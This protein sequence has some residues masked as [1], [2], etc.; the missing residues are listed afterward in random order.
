[1]IAEQSRMFVLQQKFCRA[2]IR[3][4]HTF[5]NQ[6]VRIVADNRNNLIDFT[7]VVENHLS[8]NALKLNRATLK[9]F[10][11]QDFK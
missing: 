5:F 8:L 2:N 9:T 1:M 7:V 3:R 11:L 10:F 4:Q 6:L